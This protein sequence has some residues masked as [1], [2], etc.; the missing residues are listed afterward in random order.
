M[1]ELAIIERMQLDPDRPRH[2]CWL[3]RAKGEK[4]ENVIDGPSAFGAT[5]WIGHLHEQALLLSRTHRCLV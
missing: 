1:V 5:V 4:A 3:F 2:A